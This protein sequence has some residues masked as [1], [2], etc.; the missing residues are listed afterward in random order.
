MSETRL[1]RLVP[2]GEL[3]KGVEVVDAVEVK[4]LRPEDFFAIENAIPDE[5]MDDKNWLVALG[6]AIEQAIW[7][8][9][10]AAR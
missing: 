2:T 7:E 10:Y 1:V 9:K 8:G 3:V 5:K 4:R 6:Q